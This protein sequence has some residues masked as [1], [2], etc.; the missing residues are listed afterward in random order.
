V[1]GHLEE[2]DELRRELGVVGLDVGRDRGE[3][4]V[5]EEVAQRLVARVKLVVAGVDEQA[6]RRAGQFTALKE[7]GSPERP[8]VVG[9]L[10]HDLGNLLSLRLEVRVEQAVRS[11]RKSIRIKSG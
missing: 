9:E 4:Q 8:S 5:G 7:R 11:S 2:R 1:L 3:R 10:V 6:V